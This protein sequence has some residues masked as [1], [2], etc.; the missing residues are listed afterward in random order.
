[1]MGSESLPVGKHVLIDGVEM[2]HVGGGKFEP[3]G[4]P[5]AKVFSDYDGPLMMG[6]GGSD[7]RR[8]GDP[9]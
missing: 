7:R 2:I 3:V 4:V 5:L 1:M 9:R 8:I 6:Q